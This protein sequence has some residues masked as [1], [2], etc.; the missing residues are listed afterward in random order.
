MKKHN[1]VFLALNADRSNA[2]ALRFG[3]G[4]R[5]VKVRQIDCMCGHRRK[6]RFRRLVAAYDQPGYTT[7]RRWRRSRVVTGVPGIGLPG[8]TTKLIEYGSIQSLNPPVL[9]RHPHFFA[10]VERNALFGHPTAR[11]ERFAKLID[12][13]GIVVEG[14]RFL[15]ALGGVVPLNTGAGCKHAQAVGDLVA[16]ALLRFG[17]DLENGVGRLRCEPGEIGLPG[18]LVGKLLSPKLYGERMV[19]A[20][21]CSGHAKLPRENKSTFH[22]EACQTSGN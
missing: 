5:L 21:I 11:S 2:W 10:E 6:R 19:Y 1:V 3:D 13:Q 17:F 4:Y 18:Y 22:F 12:K 20:K 7:R 8:V 15:V 14:Q 9:G 16:R